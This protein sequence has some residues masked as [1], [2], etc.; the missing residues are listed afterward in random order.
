VFFGLS[1]GLVFWRGYSLCGTEAIAK[2]LKRKLFPTIALSQILLVIDALIIIAA[3]FVYGRNIALYALVTQAILTKTIDFVLYGFETKIVQLEIITGYSDDVSSYIMNDI[4]RGVSEVMI[5]GAYTKTEYKKILT[6]CSPRESILI[7]RFV[8]NIDE[9]AFVTVI[10]VGTV[11]GN[12]EGF[13]DI[14]KEN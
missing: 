12:G 3:A 11:W 10:P 13:S 4:G 7:K 14:N 9:K 5:T 1:S 2:I 6:L 8:A